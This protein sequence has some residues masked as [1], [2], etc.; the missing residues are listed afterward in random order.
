MSLFAV[1]YTYSDDSAGRDEHR[2]AH[3]AFLGGLAD[4]G[5]VLASGPLAGEGTDQALIL[6]EH[7]STESARELLRQDPFAQQGL[8][9]AVDV[10]EWDV[11]IGDI[12]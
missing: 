3:R 5:V 2:S 8:I 4:E 6:V 12:G 9:E 11:V 7:D 10:R 1:H